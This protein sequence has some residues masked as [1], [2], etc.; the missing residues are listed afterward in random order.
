[1]ANVDGPRKRDRFGTARIFVL[2]LGIAA[3]LASAE[4]YALWRARHVDAPIAA[5]PAKVAI[6]GPLGAIDTPEGEAMIGPR[7]R[8]TGWA[9][10]PAGCR[11]KGLRRSC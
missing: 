9:L 8:L 3:V 6:E 4:F 7:V 11:A 5:T 10:D 2:V 1:M